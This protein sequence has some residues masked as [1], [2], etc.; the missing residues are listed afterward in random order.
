MDDEAEILG[1]GVFGFKAR[2]ILSGMT[3]TASRTLVQLA[4]KL[5]PNVTDHGVD[6]VLCAV[7]R[8]YED[9]VAC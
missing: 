2:G 1:I 3:C 9:E 5:G 7:L 6:Y 4:R 8:C